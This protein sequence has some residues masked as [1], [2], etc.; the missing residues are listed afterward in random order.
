MASPQPQHHLYNRV[1]TVYEDI[2]VYN[3]WAKESAEPYNVI[4]FLSRIGGD[5]SDDHGDYGDD[6][7]DDGGDHP[8][9]C[10]KGRTS[11]EIHRLHYNLSFSLH[12]NWTIIDEKSRTGGP[13]IK[14]RRLY[15]DLIRVQLSKYTAIIW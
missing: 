5:D 6:N 14:C 7:N 13:C 2:V 12:W 15:G 11:D 1:H 4:L 9:T 10:T 8:N 3:T